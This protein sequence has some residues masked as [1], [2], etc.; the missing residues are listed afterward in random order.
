MNVKSIDV[1]IYIPNPQRKTDIIE[2]LS[3]QTGVVKAMVNS[4]IEKMLQ[5]AYDPGV[6]NC[7]RLLNV[8]RRRG[9]QGYLVGM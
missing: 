2:E 4:Y 1:F 3:Q 6:T 9:Y 8:V 5:V 7:R